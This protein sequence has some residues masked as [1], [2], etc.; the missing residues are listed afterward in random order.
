MIHYIVTWISYCRDEVLF[1]EAWNMFEFYS[2][3]SIR[4]TRVIE[5]FPRGSQALGETD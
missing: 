5:I 3:H 4:V 1:G 2:I